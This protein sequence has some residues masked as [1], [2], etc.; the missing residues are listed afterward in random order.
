MRTLYRVGQ[1]RVHI[2]EVEGLGEFL[3]LEVVL[4]PGQSEQE[5]KSI[6]AMLLT[7]FGID[8]QQIVAEAYVD[9]ITRQTALASTGT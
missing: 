1:T 3:E 7:D 5:G 9:L 8:K 4:K 2:D 6:V